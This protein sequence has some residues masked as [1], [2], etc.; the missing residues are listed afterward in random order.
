MEPRRGR[1][2][3]REKMLSMRGV[4]S[5]KIRYLP[6]VCLDAMRSNPL[7]D[8]PL[9]TR[10][11]RSLCAASRASRAIVRAKDKILHSDAAHWIALWAVLYVCLRRPVAYWN[12]WA[13]CCFTI[14]LLFG[15]SLAYDLYATPGS[16][17]GVILS[18]NIVVR[19][20]DSEGYE[21]KFNEQLNAGVEFDL[22]ESRPNWLHIELTD[23]QS[24]WI[25]ATDAAMISMVFPSNQKTT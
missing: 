9:A 7:A 24:G 21:P 5:S 13:G 11:T 2:P 4:N 19:K 20:G 17:Q 15:A 22:L 6:K 16:D 18:D 8:T 10:V 14:A 25:P 1:L 12:Y 3:N 23:G